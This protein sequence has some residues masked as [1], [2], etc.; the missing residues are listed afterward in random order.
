VLVWDALDA[1]I[2]RNCLRGAFSR[3]NDVEV[4][5]LHSLVIVVKVAIL[6][7]SVQPIELELG[8]HHESRIFFN[9]L[10]IA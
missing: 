1:R 6:V 9:L 7:H 4:S 3:V 2:F 5:D 8:A 10:L